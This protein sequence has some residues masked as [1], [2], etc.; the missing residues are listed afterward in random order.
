MH[1]LEVWVLGNE[2]ACVFPWIHLCACRCVS[3]LKEATQLSN[4]LR[5]LINIQNLWRPFPA[6][7]KS[8][9]LPCTMNAPSLPL[10]PAFLL[11]E[12]PPV[13]RCARRSQPKCQRALHMPASAVPAYSC[14]S[15]LGFSWLA[16]PKSVPAPH[17]PSSPNLSVSTPS[18]FSLTHT[19]PPNLMLLVPVPPLVLHSSSE[20]LSAAS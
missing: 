7:P 8:I 4:M 10:L 11:A 2:W 18:L 16:L 3:L 17:H 12:S 13:G 15:P 14:H 1:F 19:P 20:A 6:A 9:S 5:L